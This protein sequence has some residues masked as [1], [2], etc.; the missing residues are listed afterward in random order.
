VKIAIVSNLDN[1]AGLA[2]DFT[3]LRDYLQSLEHE[4]Y[5]IQFDAPKPTDIPKCDLMISLES[6]T[7]HLFDI[8]PVHYLFVN[9]E[10]FDNAYVSLVRQHF[11]KVFTKTQEAF[12]I[13]SKLFPDRCHHVGFLA[14]DQFF[15]TA[16]ARME[17][18][19][20]GGNSATLRNTR[21]VLD[22]WRWRKNG[23]ALEIPLT[24]ICRELTEA[25]AP[26]EWVTIHQRVSE[27]ELQRLQNH[28]KYHLCPSATEGFG[29]TLREALSV[30]A[31]LITTNAP[32]MNEINNALFIKPDG[33]S[34]RRMASLYAV[35][36]LDI[37]EKIAAVTTTITDGHYARDEFIR[38]NE[39][40]KELFAPHLDDV[41]A[42]RARHTVKKAS[43]AE[44]P[45]IAFLGN[46]AAPEST[47]NMIKWA[48][49]RGLG[50]EVRTF[51]ENT[52]TLEEL[53]DG[54]DAQ[55]L[56]I[57][58]RTPGWLAVTDATMYEILTSCKNAGKKTIGLHLDKFFGIPERERL[59]GL[60]PF[61][62]CEYVFTADGSRDED[63]RRKGVNHAWLRPAV[64]EVYLHPGTP[65][66]E[67]ACDVVFVGAKGYHRE[68]PFRPAMIEFLEK[69]FHGNF[70][71]IT[72]VR[73]HALNDVYA[74][75]K[76]CVGDCIFAGI[77]NYWSDRVPETTGRGG[78]LLHPDVQGLD[79]PVAVYKPQ[80]LDDLAAKIEFWLPLE[81]ERRNT[82]K[83]CMR[84]VARKDTWTIRMREILKT[85]TG[86]WIA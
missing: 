11:A 33:Q 50:L 53:V 29:H 61:W 69:C 59:I 26:N 25:D 30:G 37:Y 28:C 66:E 60:H 39:S 62:K 56:F 81:K 51:Q 55:D 73:G 17:V 76:I 54:I 13:F 80:D 86:K 42:A 18:L 6:V 1:G 41:R 24:V 35:S 8:A 75:A 52:V 78:F 31:T 16:P 45:S 14:Q 40:F 9:P 10:W 4:V 85:V 83:M 58:V 74:S 67:Y 22:A 12:R 5:G 72:G 32:P 46:F 2:R 65:R 71:H 47:E 79:L 64:S 38:G 49:E 57:W 44:N 3:L 23:K 63:F 34:S 48:L 77:P 21:A 7:R 70:K 20:I 43:I 68:Y 27:E 19:H 82:V 84:H 15:L 36:A